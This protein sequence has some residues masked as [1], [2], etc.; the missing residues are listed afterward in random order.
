MTKLFVCDTSGVTE[1]QYETLL[2]QASLERKHRAVTYPK[3][4]D[5]V[6][7]LVAEALLRYAFPGKD[8]ETIRKEPGG[9]PCWDGCHFNLS[10]SGP[11]VVLAVGERPVG[12]DVECFRERR[13]AEA[14]AKRYFTPEEMAYADGNREHFFRVWTAKEARLKWDGTGLRM[15]LNSFSV[16]GDPMAKTWLLPGAALTLWASEHPENWEPVEICKIVLR[17]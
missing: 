12:V 7:C 5:A 17:R 11:Y 13:N 9:K 15:P 14:L 6:R 4:E 1:D 3:R 10:H 8:P 2:A 16:L